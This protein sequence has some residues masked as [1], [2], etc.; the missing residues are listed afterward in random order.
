MDIEEEE[1]K[2]NSISVRIGMLNSRRD[3]LINNL[4]H[5]HLK[6]NITFNAKTFK[7]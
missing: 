2:N 4:H 7:A 3:F 5:S 1:K 6:L